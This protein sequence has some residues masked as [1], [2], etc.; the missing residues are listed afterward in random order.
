MLTRE[1]GIARYEFDRRRV[2]P[3]RLTMGEHAHYPE[4]AE[5]MLQVYREGCGK[6]RKEL[7][8][9]VRA[10][11]EDEV[12]C[13]QRRIDAF[14]KLLD[15]H[16]AYAVSGRRNAPRLRHRVF[17]L[18]AR[19]HPLVTRADRLFESSSDEV[20]QEI[21]RELGRPWFEIERDLFADVI[22]FH[23]LETFK[24]FPDA[25]SLLSRYNVA[26]M[27]VAL[28]SAVA[29][30]VWIT[31]D[32][33]R[34]LRAARLARLMHT[35]RRIGPACYHLQLDGP[36]SVL[37][38][39]RRY[40]VSMARFLPSLLACTGWR[41][42]AV[43]ETRNRWKLSLD[44]SDGDG[45]QSHLPPDAEFDS[46]VEADFAEKWG[47]EP[48]EGWS[49]QR[50]GDFLHAGQKTFVP[51]FVFRHVTGQTVFME[52]IGFW[53]PEYIASRLETHATFRDV[54]ILLAIQDST[55]HHFSGHVPEERFLLYKSKLMIKPVLKLL[56][57]VADSQQ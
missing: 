43:V 26:Q 16:S 15:D 47:T 36:A 28:F 48:R 32:F 55:H 27:Q 12:D 25:R 49:L 18:A 13:P 46:A 44:L 9:E 19:R 39:T 34:I 30:N 53:T 31:G 54:P 6:T 3:D 7:H 29:L 1:H 38:E 56:R 22:D 37:R 57:R 52:I 10:I 4:L 24:G 5:Q 11:F 14:C 21:A 23:R 45:L 33:K 35:I 50:E 42:Q 20:R 41:M 2:V 51:D 17:R 40:G 8:R